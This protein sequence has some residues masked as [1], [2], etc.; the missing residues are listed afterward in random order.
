LRGGVRITNGAAVRWRENVERKKVMRK[1]EKE[2]TRYS[3]N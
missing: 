3:G 2:G 1:K